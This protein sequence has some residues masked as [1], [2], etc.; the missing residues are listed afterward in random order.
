M[1]RWAWTDT[2][3]QYRNVFDCAQ[4]IHEESGWRGFTDGI[5]WSLAYEH[6]PVLLLSLPG[7]DPLLDEIT[8]FI[9]RGLITGYHLV[10]RA[11]RTVLRITTPPDLTPSDEQ[12]AEQLDQEDG[13]ERRI[14]RSRSAV[15]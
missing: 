5:G 3:A 1:T 7:T 8:S 11:A 10:A 4:Q 6:F 15:W 9:A 12:L 14:R 13:P 2:R